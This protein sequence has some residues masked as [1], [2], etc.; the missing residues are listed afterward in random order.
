MK[1]SFKLHAISCLFSLANMRPVNEHLQKR[2]QINP[3]LLPDFF[4]HVVSKL[5]SLY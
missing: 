5:L 2:A 4:S 3:M 1:V